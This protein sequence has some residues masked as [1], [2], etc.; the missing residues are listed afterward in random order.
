[1]GYV[2]TGG[3]MAS[4]ALSHIGCLFCFWLSVQDRDNDIV[5]LVKSLC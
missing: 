1:M 5:Y 3:V 2:G 4:P